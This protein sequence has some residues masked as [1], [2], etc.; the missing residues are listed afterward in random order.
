MRR[1]HLRERRPERVGGG[2]VA[3]LGPALAYRP[4]VSALELAPFD[5][6]G[7]SAAMIVQVSLWLKASV[8]WAYRH[9]SDGGGG[10]A[11]PVP[12][13]RGEVQGSAPTSDHAANQVHGGL[14][15]AD[16][17]LRER[18]AEP[19]CTRPRVVG[20]PP[21]LCP[22]AK[23][24]PRQEPHRGGN[25]TSMPRSTSPRKCVTTVSARAGS[26]T[27]NPSS[28]LRSR[29]AS[30]RFADVMKTVSSSLTTAFA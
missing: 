2:H 25:G 4:P 28:M 20:S 23:R 13:L 3:I 18:S 22:G 10:R 5:R 19:G 6:G 24:D 16:S 1:R 17:S 29:A 21:D 26:R 11:K 12:G 30:V 14:P 27:T 15:R 7:G 9:S 8:V